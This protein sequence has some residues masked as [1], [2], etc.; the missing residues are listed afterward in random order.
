MAVSE[1][2]FKF[3]ASQNERFAL[4]NYQFSFPMIQAF[5]KTGGSDSDPDWQNAI[6]DYSGAPQ[7]FE[8]TAFGSAD[9]YVN[10]IVVTIVGGSDMNYD[11]Y[12]DIAGGITNGVIIALFQKGEF[13]FVSPTFKVNHD[14][15]RLFNGN[16][17]VP[18][19]R[20]GD[21]AFTATL[22]LDVPIILKGGTTDALYVQ[23]NDDF[24]S[25]I[26]HHFTAVGYT[27]N[28]KEFQGE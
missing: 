27:N 23:L 20:Q 2:L 26:G 14:Y 9:A 17:D 24:S 12:G 25:L 4:D 16:I 22:K 6:G 28:L 1:S 7:T 19:W 10:E 18:G 15:Q 5:E 21:R 11:E 3:A 13:R 8:M